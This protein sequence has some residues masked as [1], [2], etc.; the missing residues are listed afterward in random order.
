[1]KKHSIFEKVCWLND[2]DICKNMKSIF[3][4]NINAHG[5]KR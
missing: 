2:K 4:K 3:L 5:R 1:M